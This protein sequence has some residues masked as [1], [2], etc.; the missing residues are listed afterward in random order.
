MNANK[1]IEYTEHGM[2]SLVMGYEVAV[3]PCVF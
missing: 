3:N 1:K 2:R